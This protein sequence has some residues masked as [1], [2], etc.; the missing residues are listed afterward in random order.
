MDDLQR[1]GAAAVEAEHKKSSAASV[2][3]D[4]DLSQFTIQGSE[5]SWKEALSGTA[6]TGIISIKG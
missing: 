3:A 2:L 6:K 5:Q 1:E 4:S